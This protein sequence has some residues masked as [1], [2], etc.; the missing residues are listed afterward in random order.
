MGSNRFD[1]SEEEICKHLRENP[2]ELLL[3]TFYFY[4]T[5]GLQL[6]PTGMFAI[7]TLAS[8]TLIIDRTQSQLNV[9]DWLDR[10]HDLIFE[11]I[12]R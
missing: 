6:Y 4:N 10:T 3:L 9:L 1:R 11:S 2:D 8:L 5:C 12:S 7:A